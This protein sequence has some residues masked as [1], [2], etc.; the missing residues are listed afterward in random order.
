MIGRKYYQTIIKCQDA[1]ALCTAMVRNAAYN[2]VVEKTTD[3]FLDDVYT[4]AE[5]LRK[6]ID[7]V[8][9]RQMKLDLKKISS[10]Q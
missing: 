9:A 6:A 8:I 3:I 1:A 4:K 2:I 10:R 5:E 7:E